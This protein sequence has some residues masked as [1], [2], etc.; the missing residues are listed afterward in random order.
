[1]IMVG[2][3]CF[4][5]EYVVNNEYFVEKGVWEKILLFSCSVMCL[6]IIRVMGMVMKEYLWYSLNLEKFKN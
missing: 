1:M 6:M 3:I 5:N 2:R 4:E